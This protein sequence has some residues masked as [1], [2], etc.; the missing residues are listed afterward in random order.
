MKRLALQPFRRSEQRHA[1]AR[2]CSA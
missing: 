1:D 2:A